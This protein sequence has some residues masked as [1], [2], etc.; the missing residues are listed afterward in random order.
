LIGDEGVFVR[1]KHEI[2]LTAAIGH[3]PTSFA[4]WWF[5]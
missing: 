1:G 2:A 4:G 5:G 3:D